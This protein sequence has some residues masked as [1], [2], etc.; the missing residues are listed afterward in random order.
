MRPIPAVSIAAW[1]LLARDLDLSEAAETRFASLNACF[2]RQLKAG[3][4]P[5]DP[6]PGVLVSP[7][8]AIVGA[9]GRVDGTRAIQAKGLEYSIEDLLGDAALA[10]AHRDGIFVTLRL[11]GSM[12][13]RFHAPCDGR[14]DGVTYV[15]GDTWNVNPI[16]VRRI[17]RLFCRNERVVLPLQISVPSIRLT[18]V[19]IAAVLVA[20]IRLRALDRVLDLT[21]GGPTRIPCSAPF[22][23]GE[24][25][26]WFEQGSTIVVLAAGD[27]DLCE[28]V[29]PGRRLRMG[30]ALLCVRPAQV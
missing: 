16:A 23:R 17:E 4:R 22:T 27:V 13:H 29:A 19:P 6:T 7:C 2:T 14:L 24:E 9:S 1:K 12:Y 25:L 21:Y 28:G 10:R 5:I 15:S 26:G 11:S 30:E 8:D 3:A 20:S 18:L